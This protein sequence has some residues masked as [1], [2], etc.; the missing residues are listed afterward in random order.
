MTELYNFKTEY[1]FSASVL[2]ELDRSICLLLSTRAGSL[3]LDREFGLSADFLDL[4][5]ETAKSVYAAEITEKVAKYIPD[6]RVKSVSWQ[7]GGDGTIT[8]KVVITSV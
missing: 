4:P 3:P 5:P 1:T 8:S 2:A 6:V 7:Q